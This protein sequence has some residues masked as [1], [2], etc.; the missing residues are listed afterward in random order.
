MPATTYTHAVTWSSAQSGLAAGGV[1]LGGFS[2][3]QALCYPSFNAALNSI[4][5]TGA[6]IAF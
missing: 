2:I 1:A 4:T 5:S 3:E 6:V